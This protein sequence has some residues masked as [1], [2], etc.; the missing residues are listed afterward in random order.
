MNEILPWSMHS[1][2]AT[3]VTKSLDISTWRNNRILRSLFLW[4]LTLSWRLS[5]QSGLIEI[6]LLVCIVWCFRSKCLLCLGMLQLLLMLMSEIYDVIWWWFALVK[7]VNCCNLI[8]Y[9]FFLL[10]CSKPFP[11]C[12]I[13]WLQICLLDKYLCRL[14]RMLELCDWEWLHIIIVL[15]NL[16]II[17]HVWFLF[18]FYK[19]WSVCKSFIQLM[20]IKIYIK[21]WFTVNIFTMGHAAVFISNISFYYFSIDEWSLITLTH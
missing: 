11:K 16:M 4:T 1:I 9:F 13:V 18:L 20:R 14:K 8:S 2:G 10:F 7:H 6:V 21:N 12:V 19:L 5:W 3:L 17:R 15:I